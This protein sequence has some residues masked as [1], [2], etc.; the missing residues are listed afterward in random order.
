MSIRI[1]V[2]NY[3][4]NTTV[5]PTNTTLTGY[6]EV[7]IRNASHRA[8]LTQLPLV[9]YGRSKATM[10]YSESTGTGN[11]HRT[12]KHYFSSKALLFSHSYTLTNPTFTPAASRRGE[13]GGILTFPFSCLIPTHTEPCPP[14][15]TDLHRAHVLNP[16]P[17]IF[18][19]SLGYD[20]PGTGLPSAPLPDT[21][22]DFHDHIS[23]ASSTTCSASIRYSL[24]TEAPGVS[25]KS[26]LWMGDAEERADVAIYNPISFPSGPQPQ[27]SF[28]E[29][30]YEATARSLRLLASHGKEAQRRLSFRESM[31]SVFQKGKLPFV[32]LGLRMSVPDVLMLDGP[33]DQP[34][35]I[36][37][38]VA[39]LAAGV[40]GE[41]AGSD[42]E[43]GSRS[44]SRSPTPNPSATQ[45]WDSSN[46]YDN[47][48]PMQQQQPPTIQGQ[49]SQYSTRPNEKVQYPQYLSPNPGLQPQRHQDDQIPNPAIRLTR[50]TLS[51]VSLNSLRGNASDP[52]NDPLGTEYHS[53]PRYHPNMTFVSFKSAPVFDWEPSKDPSQQVFLRVSS[54][55][56]QD[57]IDI[58]QVLGIT[59]SD[60]RAAGGNVRAIG[61]NSD[62]SLQAGFSTPNWSREWM[63]EWEVRVE[64]AGDKEI[65]WKC[66]AGKE[67]PGEGGVGVGL[68]RR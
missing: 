33:D 66:R 38:G 4:P 1:F 19:G 29:V 54:D 9:F 37:I 67:G 3:D 41:Y 51:L 39:R 60:L 23:N 26:K 62:G 10:T 49:S 64:V 17:P 46:G 44:R 35:P 7:T 21:C 11:D 6:I 5:L 42:D 22:L 56:Q 68:V 24:K 31:R 53:N 63:L 61:A 15:T 28:C 55:Q 12:H 34:I 48:D 20:P 65:K 50:L 30:R 2:N 13:D 18:P 58:G 43:K 57:Y 32:T 27:I 40:G 8:S 36:R 52:T 14:E 16:R 59:T 47:K 45:G 25:T